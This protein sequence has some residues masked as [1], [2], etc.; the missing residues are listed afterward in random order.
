MVDPLTSAVPPIMLAEL[1]VCREFIWPSSEVMLVLRFWMPC[2]ELICA[3]CEVI[4]AE[5]RGVKGS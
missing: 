2:T 4:W 1:S 3:S 5:S